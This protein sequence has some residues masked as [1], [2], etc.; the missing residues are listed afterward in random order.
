LA[1]RKLR[2][3]DGSGIWAA[4]LG[5][6]AICV[7]A[8]AHAV[9]TPPTAD[10]SGIGTVVGGGPN[11]TISGGTL[12]GNNLFHSFQDFNLDTGQSAT[13]SAPGGGGEGVANVINRVTGG[14]SST[15][16][17]TI[18]SMA[19]PN[20]A[21]FFVNPSGIIFGQG[22]TIN[23]PAAA[24]F[25]TA[26][27]L[28]FE[29]GETFAATT[30]GGSTLSIANPVSFG[31]VGTESVITLNGAGFDDNDN[32]ISFLSKPLFLAATNLHISSSSFASSQITL[33]T[34][35]EM[36]NEVNL[37]SGEA[38]LRAGAITIEDSSLSAT[39][40]SAASGDIRIFGSDLKVQDNS[41]IFAFSSEGI[42]GGD[43]KITAN[44]AHIDNSSIGTRPFGDVNDANK[45]MRSGSVLISSDIINLVHA[46]LESGQLIPEEGMREFYG[47]SGNILISGHSITLTTDSKIKTTAFSDGG[48]QCSINCITGK[49]EIFADIM[50]IDNSAIDASGFIGG[51]V[52]LRGESLRIYH[53]DISSNNGAHI[54]LYG[55]NVISL[56]NVS[57]IN[58]IP[59]ENNFAGSISIRSPLIYLDKSR[60]D[61]SVD[62]II[63]LAGDG[64]NLDTS[65]FNTEG[66]I[67]ID[68][69]SKIL[70]TSGE[71][72]TKFSDMNSISM[73]SA[74]IDFRSGE[75]STSTDGG[76]DAG[77]IN[78]ISKAINLGTDH[79]IA[80][81]SSKANETV[82]FQGEDFESIISD[83]TGNAGFVV[84]DAEDGI[85]I[86]PGSSISTLSSTIGTPGGII[87]RTG[88][89][90]L[91]GSSITTEWRKPS[92]PDLE[93]SP[94]F[95]SIDID[96]DVVT[97]LGSNGEKSRVSAETSSG[98][99]GGAIRIAARS[100]DVT[101]G[102]ITAST[103]GL[104]ASRDI[105]I[106]GETVTLGAGATIEAQSLA[107]GRAGNV[108]IGGSISDG[109][110]LA[111]AQSV[112]VKDGAK[113]SASA[114]SGGSAGNIEVKSASFELRNGSAVSAQS[115][116][117]GAAGSVTVSGGLLVLEGGT[118]STLTTGTGDATGG[119]TINADTL[120][121]SG[122]E[123]LKSAI[124]SATEGSGKGG[125][126]KITAKSVDVTNGEITASTRKGSGVSDNISVAA[127]TI[128]LGA[129]AIVEARSETEG[130]AGSV[131]MGGSI[132]D[133]VVLTSSRR[134]TVANGAQIST[135]ATSAG[136]AG[137]VEIKSAS[138]ELLDGGAISS[139]TK[140]GGAGGSVAITAGSVKAVNG[141]ILASTSGSGDSKSISIAADTI[142]LG[143][144]T[145]VLAQTTGSGKAGDVLLGGSIADGTVTAG[146]Q[147][148]TVQDGAQISASSTKASIGAAGNVQIKGVAFKLLSGGTVSSE[149]NGSGAGGSVA[150]T[151]G[152]VETVN[153]S[154]SAS[155]GGSGD[156]KNVSIAADTITLGTDTK[157]LAQTTGSG[158]AGDVLLGGSIADGAV[159]TKSQSI[160]VQDGAQVS[161]SS[162]ATSNGAAGS[163]QIK[164]TTF[165]LLNGGTVS[166]ETEGLGAGGSV[167][168]T[169]GSLETVNG[170]ISAS[171]SGSGI[172][173]NVSIAAETITLGTGSQVLAQ[174]SGS[175][176][177]GSVLV[178]GSVSDTAVLS[179]AKT[180]TLKDGAEV[181]ASASGSGPSG[182][183]GIR[184]D[185]LSVLNGSKVKT[186]SSNPNPAGTIKL[187]ADTLL[188]DGQDSSV[189]SS[190][191]WIPGAQ[192][193]ALRSA[194]PVT[195]VKT[196]AAVTP[197]SGAAGALTLNARR[198]TI[199]NG[200]TI[201]TNAA[202]GSAGAITIDL[203]S[204]TDG[205]LLLD[206]A[207]ASGTI[208]TNTSGNSTA[209]QITVTHGLAIISNGGQILAQGEQ[210]GGLLS[211]GD[212]SFRINSTD[213]ENVV[214]VDGTQAFNQ[215]QDVSSGANVIEVPFVDSSNVLAGRCPAVRARGE[216]SQLSVPYTGPYA[217]NDQ[218]GS[219]ESS[220]AFI[221]RAGSCT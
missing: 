97:L 147:S 153:G 183:V 94:G 212:I 210:A 170:M 171:T 42:R 98:G 2:G 181:S 82:I 160:I 11:F 215:E 22:A 85:N 204:P 79:S 6:A 115:S 78:I 159:V 192:G 50:D 202:T 43:F 72:D 76:T 166:S 52:E 102:E 36:P 39:P 219:P 179:N 172:S 103:N 178:G 163:V 132:A 15:I 91:R 20:A 142:T 57:S 139:D 40:D 63:V 206:G 87:V 207:T 148:I 200:G 196:A 198:V 23:V 90:K 118:I 18:D 217:T 121:I 88:D 33:T 134:T 123:G 14:N 186:E 41:S 162:T 30:T 190:N 185:D 214:L 173:R 7:P 180:V 165:K 1:V 55:T 38:P 125:P 177:A 48:F 149:T 69:N 157:I 71:T 168:I 31:F 203:I 34:S 129:G 140:G 199:S 151:A 73:T 53:G 59:S 95:G 188:I 130:A 122:T 154:I 64:I 184:A 156:S 127:D 46:T 54:S 119:T 49:I 101:N 106:V 67:V 221:N 8:I 141:S 117:T 161:A 24:Y 61:V 137:S 108:L 32:E 109:T 47:E 80:E 197:A 77:N 195:S 187:V 120:I 182:N 92:Q 191:S 26:S 62:E 111:N 58:A 138:F 116:G 189:T 13:W 193:A 93:F 155:T 175:G 220:L 74:Q 66:R 10:A 100:I 65:G 126:V 104:G 56:E 136:A 25:S 44:I 99:A 135:S 133:G 152:T 176:S 174:S 96:A 158:K 216:A 89:L 51:D 145:S 27:T 112:I 12:Q 114:A 113:I 124:S 83:L 131:L 164:S 218:I 143:T 16:K 28:K 150:I 17:G 4:L 84:I 60:I 146:S 107:S 110:V 35:G 167:T 29:N 81:I 3:S 144:G 194:R 68:G 75:I 209:G 205:I 70:A 5:S 128:T 211:A 19:M 169:A 45:S 86:E 105:S 201:S 213:R 9:P 208:S 37:L 21:F